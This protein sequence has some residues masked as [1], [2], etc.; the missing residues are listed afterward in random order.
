VASFK[1]IFF[2]LFS[3]SIKKP[4]NL[5]ITFFLACFSVWHSPCESCHATKC[6][7]DGMPEQ[8]KYIGTVLLPTDLPSGVLDEWKETLKAEQARIYAGLQTKIPNE[9]AFR[10][11][12]ADASS[13]R[14]EDFLASV[15]SAWDRSVI[16]MKQR[17][18]L[19]RQ[20]NAWK[21]GVDAAFGEGGYF[22]ARV[23]AKADKFK[24]ARYVIGAVGFKADPSGSFGVWNPVVFG[25]LLLR[26]DT[27]PLRYQDANDS[28]TGTLHAV[29]KSPHG[30]L[31]TP[32]IIANAVQ[33]CVMAKFAD[34]GGLT[35]VRDTII[36]NANS[37][38]DELLNV[39]LDSTHKQEGYDV[40][41]ELSWDAVAG[42]VK[43]TVTDIHPS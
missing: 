25:A 41:Y 6:R 42:N 34:E 38:I 2:P 19:A 7:G 29:F 21:S 31:V 24:L 18:K 15:G 28:F 8:W 26:G 1:L 10:D 36:T 4:K 40:T 3:S 32:S 22:P 39:A 17:V 13:D 33:A 20:Y 5:Y 23:D 43:I 12:I 35:S 16:T 37:V 9:A 27:R 14:Y 11:R 30:N